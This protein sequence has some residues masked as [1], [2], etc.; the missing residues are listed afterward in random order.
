MLATAISSLKLE[1]IIENR[2]LRSLTSLLFVTMLSYLF[3]SY[4]VR[5]FIASNDPR[6]LGAATGNAQANV[7]IASVIALIVKLLWHFVRP[8]KKNDLYE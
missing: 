6:I 4:G 7:V 5:L 3:A 8:I 2:Y 1:P